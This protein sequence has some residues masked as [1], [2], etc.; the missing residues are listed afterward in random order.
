MKCYIVYQDRYI[1]EPP[2]WEGW[3]SKSDHR[4]CTA[5]TR[6]Q[7]VRDLYIYGY[8]WLVVDGATLCAPRTIRPLE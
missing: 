6:E 7:L 8:H 3:D 2:A 1:G 5:T 4:I